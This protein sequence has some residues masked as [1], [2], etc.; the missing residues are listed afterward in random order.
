[1]FFKVK[2]RK[3]RFSR[4]N[5]KLN[6]KKREKI[7]FRSKET[8]NK[9]PANRFGSKKISSNGVLNAKRRHER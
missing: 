2:L 7:V 4:C 1:M 8:T 3:H 6:C 9:A 5:Y